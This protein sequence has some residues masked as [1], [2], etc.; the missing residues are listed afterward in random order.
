MQK[1]KEV[2]EQKAKEDAEKAA[3]KAAAAKKGVGKKTQNKKE[4][5]RDLVKKAAPTIEAVDEMNQDDDVKIDLNR[6][7]SAL[8]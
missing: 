2:A 7:Q 5:Q 4:E 3:K 8:K 6:T 1:A